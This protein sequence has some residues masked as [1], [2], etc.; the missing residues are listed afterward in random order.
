MIGYW[1]SFARTGTPTAAGQPAWPKLTGTN[2]P[3]LQLDPDHIKTVD[4]AAEHH[5]GFWQTIQTSSNP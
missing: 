2:G 1:T 4:I 5:C 3:T